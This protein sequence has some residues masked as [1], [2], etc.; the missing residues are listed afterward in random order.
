MWNPENDVYIEENFSVEDFEDKK[1]A[2][3]KVLCDQFNLDENKPLIVFIGRLVGEKAADML[4]SAISDSIYHMEGR[5]NFLVLGSGEHWD[6]ATTSEFERT[7][8]R[9]L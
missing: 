1:V 2:N 8:L 6:R 5:M 4:P 7:F 9:I 3:K